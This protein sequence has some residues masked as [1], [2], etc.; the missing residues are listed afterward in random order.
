MLDGVVPGTAV[1]AKGSVAE[2]GWLETM[3]V[4]GTAV[5]FVASSETAGGGAAAGVPVPVPVAAPVAG[6]EAVDEAARAAGL[7]VAWRASSG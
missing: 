4:N 3:S 7:G 5:G 1:E 6:V 2:L